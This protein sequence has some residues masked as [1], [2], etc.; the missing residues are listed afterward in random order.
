LKTKTPRALKQLLCT[1]QTIRNDKQKD[2]FIK[3]PFVLRFIF[4][5]VLELLQEHSYTGNVLEIYCLNNPR[6]T[7]KSRVTLDG[8]G[9]DLPS[10]Q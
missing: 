1:H 5:V 9:A 4:G 7:Y 2:R 6:N 3:C 10:L 8:Q